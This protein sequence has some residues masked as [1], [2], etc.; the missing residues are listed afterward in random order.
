MVSSRKVVHFSFPFGRSSENL[1]PKSSPSK[2]NT[3]PYRTIDRVCV[4]KAKKCGQKG[5][6][7]KSNKNYL[8][9]FCMALTHFLAHKKMPYSEISAVKKVTN[10]RCV[11]IKPNQSPNMHVDSI[12][13]TKINFRVA[14]S[15]SGKKAERAI[16]GLSFVF[17]G[18]P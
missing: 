17:L 11:W 9:D 18:G 6:K 2:S 14:K 7:R 12:F 1:T 4:Q 5:K 15:G 8:R 16:K 13:C 3:I 10:T